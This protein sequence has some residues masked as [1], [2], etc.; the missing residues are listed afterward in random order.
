MFRVRAVVAEK[1]L[2][3]NNSKGLEDAGSTY[4]IC[5]KFSDSSHQYVNVDKAFYDAC[6][7]DGDIYGE[8]RLVLPVASADSSLPYEH[9]S[10]SCIA[11]V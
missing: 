3:Y 5:V 2:H 7:V 4:E 6:P 11:P 1:V 8:F 9:G 10:P